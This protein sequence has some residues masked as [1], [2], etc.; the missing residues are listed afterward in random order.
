MVKQGSAD[1]S[2]EVSTEGV[3]EYGI[4]ASARIVGKDLCLI[5]DYVEASILNV[6][7]SRLID[8]L[9]GCGA[10]CW[11]G[12]YRFSCCRNCFSTTFG[13]KSTVLRP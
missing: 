8:L 1:A 13:L 11:H 2:A 7:L 5:E 6:E 9:V 4:V 10:A 12:G 3:D